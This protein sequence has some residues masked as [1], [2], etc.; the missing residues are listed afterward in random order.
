MVRDDQPQSRNNE[1]ENQCC[2]ID[3][4][5]A[6]DG[7]NPVYKPGQTDTQVKHEKSDQPIGNEFGQRKHETADGGHVNLLDR[8]DL[9]FS[10]HVQGGKEAAEHD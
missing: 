4:E 6:T 2:Q 3:G 1:N 10:H 9:L 5:Q 7:N 8:A